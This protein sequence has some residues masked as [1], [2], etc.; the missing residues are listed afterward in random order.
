MNKKI[1]EKIVMEAIGSVFTDPKLM[2]EWEKLYGDVELETVEEHTVLLSRNFEITKTP[3]NRYYWKS[4]LYGSISSR[5][6]KI[7][8]GMLGSIIG[9][10]I[11]KI[12]F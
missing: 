3:D 2:L 8:V 10:L 6:L 11:E 12:F 1:T 9:L 4:R 7:L 5:R